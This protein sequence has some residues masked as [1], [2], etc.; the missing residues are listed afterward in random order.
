[1]KKLLKLLVLVSFTSL[2][3]NEYATINVQIDP[4]ATIKEGSPNIYGSIEL[5]SY[6]IYVNG[7]FQ[8]LD[9]LKGGYLDFGGSVG[10]NAYT[11]KFKQTRLLGGVRLGFIKRGYK[12]NDTNTYPL[13]GI[14]GG[15]SQKI[16]DKIFVTVR[17]TY[18][19]RSDFKYSG[20]DPKYRESLY[21]GLGFKL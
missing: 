14:E 21:I 19:Y 17:G 4:S 9:G 5:V 11:S 6:M 2:A 8:M 20:A 7:N 16:T 15:V 18:D 13:F 10:L 3:Q 12:E 1:M